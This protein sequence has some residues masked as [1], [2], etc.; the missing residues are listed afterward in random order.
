MDQR[1]KTSIKLLGLILSG[2]LL[3]AFNSN[4]GLPSGR[5]APKPTKT[6]T[7]TQ[8]STPSRTPTRT[9]TP[10]STQ[11]Y[12]PTSTGTP[13]VCSSWNL[14]SDFS[15]DPGQENPKRD[16][17][18]NLGVWGFMGSGSLPRNPANYYLLPNFKPNYAGFANYPTYDT[19]T[20]YPHIGF[21][22]GATIVVGAI[23]VPYNT[24]DVHPAPDQMA[25]IAW[26]SP[27][28]GYVSIAGGVSDNNPGCGDGILWYIDKN[29]T[30]LASGGYP[31]GGAQT[32][33][34]GTG[35]AN[36]DVVA[37]NTGD[38]VYLGIH[39]SGDHTCD[40]GRIDLLINVTSPPTPTNTPTETPTSTPTPASSFTYNRV[41]AV[42]YADQWAHDRNG[43]YPL[44]DEIGCGCSNCTNY[45]SQ[46]LHEGGYEL[47]TG[48][49]DWDPY[50]TF[51]WWYQPVWYGGYVYSQTWASTE[52]FY[53]YV[54][55]YSN[56]FDTNSLSTDEYP[57]WLTNGDFILLD[58][59]NND[60]HAVGSDGRPDHAR[61]VVG[62]GGVS[63]D[64]NDYTDGCGAFQPTPTIAPTDILLIN[65]NCTDRRH[66]AWNY[67]IDDVTLRAYVHVK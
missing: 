44:A 9:L 6:L 4:D 31:N 63:T 52:Y 64:P 57:S 12:T 11:T 25:I 60:T 20:L 38:V 32:F 3:A 66:V 55:N 15:N 65:Q 48:D 59:M 49:Q 7:P 45:I 24:I 54:L 42:A 43:S 50:E 14:A 19:N 10:T 5:P 56:E 37:V 36:L 26:H 27:V 8:T 40:D 1:A 21:N 58:L 22:G 41:A 62:Y 18:N 34:S 28:N 61:V 47:R 13:F 29:S 23:T 33:A 67:H 30:N 17:C 35:S 39:P 46:V 16:S 51:D 53:T 2:F